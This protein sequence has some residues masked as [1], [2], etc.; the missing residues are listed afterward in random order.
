VIKYPLPIYY[1]NHISFPKSRPALPS[2]KHNLG[3]NRFRSILY[4][5]GADGI[6]TPFEIIVGEKVFVFYQFVVTSTRIPE[7]MVFSVVRPE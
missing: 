1:F 6:P 3:G 7:V 4:S 2:G 5:E